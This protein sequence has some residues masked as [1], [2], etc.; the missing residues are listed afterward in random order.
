MQVVLLVLVSANMT[1]PQRTNIMF[2]IAVLTLLA[3]LAIFMSSCTL[4]VGSFGQLEQEKVH[5]IKIKD[6]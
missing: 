3:S 5:G 1:E 6:K 4:N 2:I